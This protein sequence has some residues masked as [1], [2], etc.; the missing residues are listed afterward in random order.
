M[1]K[2]ENMK[3]K[4]TNATKLPRLK[5]T[6]KAA[7]KSLGCFGAGVAFTSLGRGLM[8]AGTNSLIS[9]E[10]SAAEKVVGGA[11][12]GVGFANQ[13]IGTGCVMAGVGYAI[14]TANLIGENINNILDNDD[15]D[16]DD[17]DVEIDE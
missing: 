7:A 4:I 8:Q 5:K 12:I 6:G 2:M 9:T 10:S 15:E 13:L 3:A 14:D 17:I 1:K 11:A 16:F